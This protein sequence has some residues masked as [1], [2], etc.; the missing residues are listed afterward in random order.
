MS[1][2]D[3]AG[4]PFPALNDVGFTDPDDDTTY[5]VGALTDYKDLPLCSDQTAASTSPI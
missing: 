5:W 3:I 1:T 4:Q 2:K